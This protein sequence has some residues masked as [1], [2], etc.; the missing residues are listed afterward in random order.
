M[1]DDMTP[2]CYDVPVKET[3][4]REGDDTP[5]V[6]ANAPVEAPLVAQDLRQ[7]TLVAA[8]GHAVHTVVTAHL[9]TRSYA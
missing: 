1:Y 3:S 6:Q 8:R 5:G 2:A 7:Q 9:H 4:A